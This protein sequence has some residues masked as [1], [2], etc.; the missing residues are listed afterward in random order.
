MSSG[1]QFNT[2][3]PMMKGTWVNPK[4]GHKFTVR[5]CYFENNQFMVQ[6]TDGQILD[7]NT[8]QNYIQCTDKDGVDK[9]EEIVESTPEDLVIPED[10]LSLMD[11]GDTQP[12]KPVNTNPDQLIIERIL[13]ERPVPGASITITWKKFPKSQIDTL[14]STL[15]I[16][17]EEI[18]RFYEQFIDYGALEKDTREAIANY[19]TSQLEPKL[20]TKPTNNARNKPSNH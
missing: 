2:D 6:T 18:A 16:S 11:P 7:Y 1:I 9:S 19:I 15:G 20:T 14:V 5:D 8:I 4:T 3:G 12:T 10:V 13:R 17:K